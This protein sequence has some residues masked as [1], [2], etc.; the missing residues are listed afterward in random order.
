MNDVITRG[1][2]NTEKLQ[3]FIWTDVDILT[4]EML[5][6]ICRCP[7]LRELEIGG[8][9]VS[10]RYDPEILPKFT[11][12]R[13]IKLILPDQ[14]VLKILPAWLESLEHPLQNLSIEKATV[15]GTALGV[16]L[17]CILNPAN[18]GASSFNR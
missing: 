16:H 10:R 1:L 7:L 18:T 15:V 5:H 4:S 2:K 14:H 17:I 3:C 12:I 9:G 6:A 8:A 13:K 11:N